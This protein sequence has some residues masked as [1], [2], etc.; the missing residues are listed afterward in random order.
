[1]NFLPRLTANPYT[2]PVL[3]TVILSLFTLLSFGLLL[4]QFLAA[5][6]F[7]LHR[8][9]TDDA[10]SFA[11]P[12]VLFK[13]LK[14]LDE[15]TVGCLRSWFT[16]NYR[17]A[18]RILFGVADAD[19]PVVPVVRELLNEFPKIKAE[20]VS[21]GEPHGPN[22]KVANLSRLYEKISRPRHDSCRQG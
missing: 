3:V 8:R 1:M 2:T 22:A 19:D 20:L 18:T 4:W 9:I 12:V 13:P 14:G 5:W 15:H 11:P 7:P 17:G 6:R 21:T 10:G 16:Q